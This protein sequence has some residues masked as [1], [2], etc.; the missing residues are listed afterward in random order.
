MP[1]EMLN[2]AVS[3]TITDAKGRRLAIR[4]L[5]VVEQL[6]LYEMAGPNST[7]SPWLGTAMMVCTVRSIG[8]APQPF[9]RTRDQLR[10]S[11]G[12]LGRE[13]V[14]ALHADLSAQREA[15]EAAAGG[16]DEA[17][18]AESEAASKMDAAKN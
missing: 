5:D 16:E 3:R 17:A 13:G 2:D 12:R 15:L 8:D 1:V 14:D 9:P 11:L 6:D 4:D 7:N 18:A 10:G